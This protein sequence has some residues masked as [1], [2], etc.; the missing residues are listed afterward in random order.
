MAAN[1]PAEG[2]IALSACQLQF[3]GYALSIDDLAVGHA[4]INDDFNNIANI[5]NNREYHYVCI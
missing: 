5:S 1:D 3:F 2:C 4:R